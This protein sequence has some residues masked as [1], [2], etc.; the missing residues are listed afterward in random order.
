MANATFERV[1]AVAGDPTR[2]EIGESMGRSNG[3]NRHWLKP[4]AKPRN[5]VNPSSFILL[6]NNEFL[7]IVF[8]FIFEIHLI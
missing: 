4:T 6:K 8:Y 2:I 7:M 3:M 1:N 5:T